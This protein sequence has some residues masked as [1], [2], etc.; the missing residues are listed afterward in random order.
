MAIFQ[1]FKPDV[2]KCI[3]LLKMERDFILQKPSKFQIEIFLLIL[4]LY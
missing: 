3:I 2:Q 4:L 1:N